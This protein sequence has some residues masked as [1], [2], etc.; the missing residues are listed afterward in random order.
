MVRFVMLLA[1]AGCAVDNPPAAAPAL[2][3]DGFRCTVQPV[4]AARCAFAACHGTRTRPFA[5]YAPGRERYQIGWDRPT[6]PITA[7][8]LDANFGI[9]S[10]F[11]TT[12][13]TGEPWLLAKPLAVGEGGYYHRGADLYG[14]GDVF[15]TR[16]DPGY[17]ALAAW[18]GGATAAPE[19]TPITE[20]GP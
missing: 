8:E 10:G 18:I 19:C 7:A 14:A 13:A 16:D 1:I 3:R 4:L 15:D 11:T 20:V 5:I 12:T 6:A 9:A 2:D 17:R